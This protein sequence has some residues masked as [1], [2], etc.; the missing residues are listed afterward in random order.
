MAAAP[1]RPAG[2]PPQWEFPTLSRKMGRNERCNCG[3][4]EQL[5]RR[6]GMRVIE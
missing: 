4:G 2:A 6:L 1:N 3:S 5:K